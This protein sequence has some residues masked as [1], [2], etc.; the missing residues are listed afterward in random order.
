MKLLSRLYPL[1]LGVVAF[2][3]IRLT[4]DLAKNE[5]LW[6]NSMQYHLHALGLLTIAV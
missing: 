6:S 3:C 1:F 2:N 5:G 4:T